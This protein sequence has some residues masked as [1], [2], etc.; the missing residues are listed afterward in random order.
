MSVF[1]CKVSGIHWA[2]VGGGR[3]EQEYFG[4]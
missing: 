3:D 1:F 4:L 2:G